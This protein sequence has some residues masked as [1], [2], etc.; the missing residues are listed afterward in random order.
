MDK[1]TK[2]IAEELKS[3]DE[4]QP[5]PDEEHKHDD[6]ECHSDDEEVR[7]PLKMLQETIETMKDYLETEYS[8]SIFIE[9]LECTY[10]TVSDALII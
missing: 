9:S 3:L 4:P 6:C 10:Y 5:Q 7:T 2:D 8:Q 1:Y